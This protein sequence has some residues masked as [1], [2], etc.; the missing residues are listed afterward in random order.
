MK[1]LE[2]SS[3]IR[4][5]TLSVF[6]FFLFSGISNI[7]TA[8]NYGMRD[9]GGVNLPTV[10]YWHSGLENDVTEKGAQFNERDFGAIT[11]FYFKSAAIKTWKA[12]GGDVTGAQFKY[13]VWKTTETEPENYV[14]RSVGWSSNDGGG[15]QTWSGFGEEIPLLSGLNSGTYNLKILFAITGTGVPG[16]TENGPF[17]A[18][19]QI[20][21]QSSAAEILSFE[22]ENQIGETLI[23]SE[24]ATVLVRMVIGSAVT[25]LQPTITVSNGATISP[26]SGVEQNFTNSV[27][28]TVTAENQTTKVWTASVQLIEQPVYYSVTFNVDM[29]PAINGGYFNPAS[30]YVDVGGNFNQYSGSGAMT[31]GQNNIYTQTTN[32]IFEAGEELDFKFRINGNWQTAELLGQDNRNYIVSAVENI[33]NAIYNQPGTTTPTITFANLQFPGT[34]TI[35]IGGTVDV[36]AQVEVT[37]TEIN[38]ETGYENLTVWIGISNEDSNPNTWTSWVQAA[39]NGISEI[40]QKPEYKMAVGGDLTQAGTYYYASRFQL[41][42]EGFIYGGFSDMGGGFWSGGENASGVLT[43][44]EQVQYFPVTFQVTNNNPS[45]TVVKIK[46]TFNEWTHVDMENTS[47]NIWTKT[48][49]VAPGNYEWGVSNQESNWLLPGLNLSFTMSS[50][51]TIT[52]TTTY[53]IPLDIS[54]SVLAME[55]WISYMAGTV[56]NSVTGT[57]FHGSNL[58][59]FNESS[60]LVLKGGALKTFKAGDYD[61]T[62]ATMYYRIY[63]DAETPGNFVSVDLPWKENLEEPS[64]QIWENITQTVNGSQG[65]ANG[66]YH[67]ET[68]FALH[69]KIGV[70]TT[71]LTLTDDNSGANYKATFIFESNVGIMDYVGELSKLSFYPNPAVD[72]LTIDLPE[73]VKDWTITLYNSQ[74]QMLGIWPNGYRVDVSGFVS[75]VY[76]VE[77][78]IERFVIRQKVLILRD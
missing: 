62:A 11:A 5:A 57:V 8:Q 71:V 76:M 49:N 66:T 50:N 58:G 52:G 7:S 29:T 39:Y 48:F 72:N 75:G 3:K 4:T 37:N 17:T 40:T 45:V 10:T 9:D 32:Q 44:T 26:E 55:R 64:Q 16:I 30:D 20:T 61:V 23:D 70:Q 24:N 18:T 6:T 22:I 15:N 38:T 36:Y 65:L 77:L 31:A 74:G 73:Y 33:Y 13:K 43:V 60:A 54:G 78:K 46:G 21:Q 2:Y 12:E 69:Y 68:Y 41:N 67:L 19:F 42:N 34:A 53:I 1:I 59:T 47:G 25:A 51:G 35:E 56:Q 28:Y 14:V 27:S 63:K